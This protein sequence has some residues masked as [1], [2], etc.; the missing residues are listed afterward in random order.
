M[1]NL[2]CV[3]SE[4]LLIYTPP[5]NTIASIQAEFGLITAVSDPFS[6]IVDELTGLLLFD[7][8]N[9]SVGDAF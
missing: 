5:S 8:F 1:V 3:P 2:N 6:D 9:V 7:P 4:P